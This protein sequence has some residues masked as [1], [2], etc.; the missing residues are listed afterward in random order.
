[1]DGVSLLFFVCSLL[2]F[3]MKS[4]SSVLSILA[5]LLVV[6]YGIPSIPIG[7][8]WVTSFA[9]CQPAVADRMNFP[10]TF[11]KET[12]STSDAIL[13]TATQ[14]IP[15]TIGYDGKVE[16]STGF[17][18]LQNT[19]VGI[20]CTGVAQLNRPVLALN[21]L[22]TISEGQSESYCDAQMVCASGSCSSWNGFH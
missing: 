18:T 2:A 13:F 5:L 21:Y 8:T 15:S 6:T 7:G 11:V 17:V 20:I 14:N 10:Q 22:C 16:L 1:M 19:T 4:W 3:Q 9:K 12:S